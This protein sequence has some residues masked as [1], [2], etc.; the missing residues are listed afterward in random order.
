M[1]STNQSSEPE[2]RAGISNRGVVAM[3]GRT[4]RVEEVLGVPISCVTPEGAVERVGELLA[5]LAP[6]LV[7]TADTQG[8]YVAQKDPELKAIYRGSAMNTPDSYGVVWALGKA[9]VRD[10]ARVTGVDLAYQLLAL[11]AER[12][13][14]VFFL[15]AAP[16]VAQ[17]AAE[18]MTAE[19]PGLKVAGTRDGFWKPSDEAD[20]VS[21]VAATKPHLLLVALGIPRQ[22][23][24][25]AK[26]QHDLGF[27]VGIGVGGTFDVM[28]GQVK[29]APKIVQAIRLEWLWRLILNPKKA[30]KA[31][32]IPRFMLRVLKAQRKAK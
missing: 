9:G 31:A 10:Q 2:V 15:G 5:D 25:L 23:K 16:G 27:R 6:K 18:R 22:E 4:I 7:L 30:A 32:A 3:S 17:M 8:C 28:S 12:G 14:S 21:S 11:C 13:H 29:R 19:F 24:F 20:V 26:Y 1:A